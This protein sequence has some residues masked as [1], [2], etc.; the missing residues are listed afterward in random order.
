VTVRFYHVEEGEADKMLKNFNRMIYDWERKIVTGK[1]PFWG[2]MCMLYG[3]VSSKVLGKEYLD[4][5]ISRECMVDAKVLYLVAYTISMKSKEAE[6]EMERATRKMTYL[7]EQMLLKGGSFGMGI[8]VQLIKKELASSFEFMSML[9][10]RQNN[11]VK[12]SLW[13]ILS[14]SGSV[15]KWEELCTDNMA[16]KVSQNPREQET[17]VMARKQ[18]R[19]WFW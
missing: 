11:L 3:V 17:E 16:K 8:Q 14:E 5:W 7:E 15:A 13:P 18:A 6:L 12:S 1:L 10:N 4:L 2:D 19:S 9:H